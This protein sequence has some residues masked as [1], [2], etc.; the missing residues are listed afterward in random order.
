MRRRGSRQYRRILSGAMEG[1]GLTV[2]RPDGRT[3]GRSDGLT[4]G[5]SDGLTAYQDGAFRRD[6]VQVLQPACYG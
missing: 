3:V 1:W 4:V 6:D 2:G 5:R